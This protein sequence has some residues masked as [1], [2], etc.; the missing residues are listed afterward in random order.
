MPARRSTSRYFAL[1]IERY[2]SLTDF[3]EA[4]DLFIDNAVELGCAAISG[5]LEE[6]GLSPQDV[7]LIITTTV[8]GVAAPSLDARIAGRLGLRP[9][10]RRVPIFGLGCVA[11]AAGVARLA[12][13]PTGCARRC[14]GAVVGGVVF[15][16][17]PAQRAVDGPSGRQW[18]VRR[19]RRS[20]GRRR[21]APRRAD[22]C[23]AGPT[24]SHRA[25][26]CTQTRWARW[27]GTSDPRDLSWCCRRICRISLSA[28]CRTT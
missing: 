4:N 13:L 27:A 26:A 2:P 16:G 15:A 18:P 28:T 14:R 12:R 10:V 25:A 7:D 8:T 23:P 17:L 1:P 9:D 5:A 3:G 24:S 21:R 6:A 20:G 19:R 11:G 22:R